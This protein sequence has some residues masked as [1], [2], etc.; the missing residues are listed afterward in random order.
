MCSAGQ[1]SNHSRYRP[2]SWITVPPNR[3]SSSVICG[4]RNGS[5]RRAGCALSSMPTGSKLG[6]YRSGGRDWR[7]HIDGRSPSSVY[8]PTWPC[9][10]YRQSWKYAMFDGSS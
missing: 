8:Q 7:V 3:Y 9:C 5:V 1:Q 2:R 4:F 6:S 10:T